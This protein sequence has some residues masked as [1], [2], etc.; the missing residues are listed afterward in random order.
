MLFL[1]YL[2][3]L[4]VNVAEPSLLWF[5]LNDKL[6]NNQRWTF[7]H[8]LVFVVIITIATSILNLCR[9]STSASFL[10]IFLFSLIFSILFYNDSI[11]K[12]IIWTSVFLVICFFADSIVTLIPMFIFNIDISSAQIGA[13]IRFPL[14][15]LYIS[16]VM[17]FVFAFHF[18][19]SNNVLLLSWLQRILYVL[20][21]MIG[22]F[23]GEYIT[24]M[25]VEASNRF[26][27]SHFTKGMFYII[28]IYIILFVLLL[29]YIY[30]LACLNAMNIDLKNQQQLHEMES[31]EF[32]NLIAATESLR[33][34]KHE[35]TL[36]LTTVYFML[37]K[38]EYPEAINYVK[39]YMQL[40]DEIHHFPSTGN[41]A[42]DCIISTKIPAARNK[43]IQVRSSIFIPSDFPLDDLDTCSL[44]GNLFNNAIENCSKLTFDNQGAVIDFSIKPVQRMLLIRI[45]NPFDGIVR[46]DNQGKY[47]SRK[48]NYEKNGLGLNR[49]YEIVEQYDGLIDISTTN[50]IFTVFIMIPL[51]EE[52]NETSDS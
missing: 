6:S 32:T 5:F 23:F 26:N 43:G 39:K 18:F 42:I 38:E 51:K 37:C 11:T 45:E 13:S 8:K 44:L 7:I 29:I 28:I 17:S 30:K 46:I 34:M 22:L 15:L 40:T 35:L 20:I 16:T 47:L 52:P 25:T 14:T 1:A 27:D 10:L 36:H 4:L 12:K 9:V 48:R 24:S 2:W 33:Q 41:T 19:K 21:C 31:K 49:I 50:N 3:E